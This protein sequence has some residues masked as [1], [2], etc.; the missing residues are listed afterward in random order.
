MVCLMYLFG[1]AS[2]HIYP[3]AFAVP[4]KFTCWLRL[5]L[6]LIICMICNYY[7]C[8]SHKEKYQ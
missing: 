6:A 1:I 5:K 8:A 7:A 4:T 2:S 3:T